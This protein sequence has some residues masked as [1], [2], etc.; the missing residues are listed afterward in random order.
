[1][2]QGISLT[3][4]HRLLVV[5]DT[6]RL[7]AL[8]HAVFIIEQTATLWW[9][10]FAKYDQY[11]KSNLHELDL[12][13][14]WGAVQDL[15]VNDLLALFSASDTDTLVRR[16]ELAWKDWCEGLCSYLFVADLPSVGDLIAAVKDFVS[17]LAD[18]RDRTRIALLLDDK[19]K[20][21][22]CGMLTPSS[23]PCWS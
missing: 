7:L 15:A 22:Y 11:K 16:S 3:L 23:T 1:M 9:D 13:P 2:S 4:L 17:T 21:Q 8:G 6:D 12:A 14:Y 20:Q 19:E 10:Y 5:S 18:A